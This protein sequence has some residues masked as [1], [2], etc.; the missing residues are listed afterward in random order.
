[1]QRRSILM[2]KKC[3]FVKLTSERGKIAAKVMR[4]FRKTGDMQKIKKDRDKRLKE[5]RKWWG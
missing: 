5:W 1:M 2:A 4:Q 3:T